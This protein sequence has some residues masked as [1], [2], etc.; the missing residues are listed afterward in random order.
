MDEYK[1][2]LDEMIDDLQ[3]VCTKGNKGVKVKV[4]LLLTAAAQQF[5]FLAQGMTQSFQ[6]HLFLSVF[7]RKQSPF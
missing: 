2:M 7:C 5:K 4:T 6:Q 3:L 1:K